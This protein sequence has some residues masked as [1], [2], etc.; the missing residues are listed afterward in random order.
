MPP[1]ANLN[2]SAANN[3]Q[4]SVT[5]TGIVKLIASVAMAQPI[6]VSA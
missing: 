4:A 3:T 1:V 5:R 6:S 2:Q